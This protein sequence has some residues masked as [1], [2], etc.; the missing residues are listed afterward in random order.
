MKKIIIVLLAV[1]IPLPIFSQI[2]FKQKKAESLPKIEPYDS[3]TNILVDPDI[4]TKEFSTKK[5]AQLYADAQFQKIIGQK[6]FVIP[7]TEKENASLNSW[8]KDEKAK[9]RNRY[10]TIT[11][12]DYKIEKGYFSGRYKIERIIYLLKDSNNRTA[13]LEVSS[14][15]YADDLMIVGYYEK[16]KASY[17]NKTF[18]YTGTTQFAE[19]LNRKLKHTAKDIKTDEIIRIPIG[20]KWECTNLQ[21]FDDD[22]TVQLYFTFKSQNGQ[23]IL[24][25]VSDRLKDTMENIEQQYAF[26][27][28]FMDVREYDLYMKVLAEKYGKDN[29]EL[30]LNRKVKIGMTEEMCLLSWGTPNTVNSTITNNIKYEQWVYSDSSYLYFENGI[31][32]TMQL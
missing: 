5:E 12:F 15:S 6:L 16:L 13:D 18:I 27:S 31:L 22:V 20:S 10:Y 8:H 29:A 23:E 14:Y 26:A 32:T 1:L 4:I 9:F 21:L 19:N 7:L 3:L 30:I 17:L 2:E 24:A 11:G 25:R 28:C